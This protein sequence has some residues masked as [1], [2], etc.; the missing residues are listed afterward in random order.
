MD[1][2]SCL[3]QNVAQVV[4]ARSMPGLRLQSAQNQCYPV[5]RQSHLMEQNAQMMLRIEVL[6]VQGQNVT[7]CRFCLFV[8][9]RRMVREG[10]FEKTAFVQK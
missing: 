8:S 7:V 5:L 3:G 10:I 4:V 1:Q 6:W 9:T 2:V